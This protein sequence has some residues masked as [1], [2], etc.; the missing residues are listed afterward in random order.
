MITVDGNEDAETIAKMQ[1]YNAKGVVYEL[2][3]DET[4]F[5]DTPVVETKIRKI[6]DDYK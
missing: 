3:G 1:E 6:V 2:S 5:V 4:Y